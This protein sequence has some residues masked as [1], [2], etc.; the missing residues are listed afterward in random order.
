MVTQTRAIP[1]EAVDKRLS[2]SVMPRPNGM[3][4]HDIL[5]MTALAFLTQSCGELAS[6]G[7]F[8]AQV[9]DEGISRPM[10]DIQEFD[11]MIARPVT[12]A[13]LSLMPMELSSADAH[14]IE[15]ALSNK[16]AKPTFATSRLPEMK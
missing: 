7:E 2:Q 10:L 6:A 5:A 11:A 3:R 15:T 8:L 4:N 14:V 12:R 13:G 9:Q 1:E 16:S